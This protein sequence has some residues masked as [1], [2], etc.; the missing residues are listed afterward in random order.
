MYGR[1]TNIDHKNQ[2]NVGKYTIHGFYGKCIRFAEWWCFLLGTRHVGSWEWDGFGS[3]DDFQVSNE[4]IPSW[5]EYTGDDKLHSY[6]G[7]IIN[8]YKDHPY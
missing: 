4:K 2:P 7:T 6:I 1:F 5:L 3:V 8:H